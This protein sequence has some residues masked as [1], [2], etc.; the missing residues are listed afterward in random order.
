MKPHPTPFFED[1]ECCICMDD[2]NNEKTQILKCR[3]RFH[4]EC[5]KEWYGTDRTCPLCREDINIGPNGPQRQSLEN[6]INIENERHEE[7][8]S[9][10]CISVGA[11]MCLGSMLCVAVPLPCSCIINSICCAFS[12]YFYHKEKKRHR[13]ITRYHARQISSMS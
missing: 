5:I 11:N 10:I 9:R 8:N 7:I 1:E 4:E 2:L 12:A 6:A 13:M 3:H